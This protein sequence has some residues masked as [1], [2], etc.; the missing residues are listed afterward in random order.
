MFYKVLTIYFNPVAVIGTVLY[1]E[2]MHVALPRNLQWCHLLPKRHVFNNYES[3]SGHIRVCCHC[4]DAGGFS[5]S[6]VVLA[7]V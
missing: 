6:V 3:K 7:C 2:K 4:G 1:N 5:Y